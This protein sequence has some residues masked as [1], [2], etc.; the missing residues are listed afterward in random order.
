MA[1]N[2]NKE[3]NYVQLDWSTATEKNSSY[4]DVQR[5]TD[6]I[7]FQ[8]I[9]K[10]QAAGNSSSIHQYYFKDENASAP[11]VIYYKLVEHDIDG[12]T[13]DSD[14]RSIRNSSAN[15][16]TV[17]PNPSNGN[18]TVLVEGNDYK[19]ISLLVYNTLGQVV[20]QASG[21]SN[22]GSTYSKNIDIQNLAAGVYILHVSSSGQTWTKK[23][24][25]E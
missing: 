9:G 21:N 16:V 15:D 10:V 3:S 6:G 23:I 18:F 20:Y 14:I 25:K 19:T 7:H 24:I 13:T 17:V 5:S 4:Y 22:E 11:G 12:K 1:F 8:S 2:A